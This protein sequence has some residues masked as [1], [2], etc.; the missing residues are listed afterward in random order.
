MYNKYGSKVRLT[1]K[2][3]LDQLWLGTKRLACIY[4]ASHIIH[5]FLA[6]FPSLLS[7]ILIHPLSFLPPISSH[8]SF[9]IHPLC[10]FISFF[11]H[12]AIDMLSTSVSH[13][14]VHPSL[15]VHPFLLSHPFI[16][17]F[18]PNPSILSCLSIPLSLNFHPFNN[19]YPLFSYVHSFIH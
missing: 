16:N 4:I 6:I 8:S 15:F 18:Y 2:L 17:L 12:L 7:S 13:F 19:S 3:E 14:S 9:L 5:Y 11:I 10:H 1:F